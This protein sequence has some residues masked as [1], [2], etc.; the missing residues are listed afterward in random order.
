MKR[1]RAEAASLADDSWRHGEENNNN[2]DDDDDDFG[3]VEDDA[4]AR[5]KLQRYFFDEHDVSAVSR[6][7]GGRKSQ[8]G[9]YPMQ[10]EAHRLARRGDSLSLARLNTEARL[11]GT[12]GT[13]ALSRS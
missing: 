9:M 10:F 8:R 1:S 13:T 6:S 7:T 2:D 3:D 5:Q 11:R 4:T 12:A